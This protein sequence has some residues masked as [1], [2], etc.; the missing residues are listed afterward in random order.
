MTEHEH[1]MY[2]VLGKISETDAPIVFKGALISKLILAEH[3]FTQLE[4]STTDIDA[5]WVD[6]PP[7]MSYL[8]NTIQQSLGNMRDQL[9]AV[10][11]RDYEEK[12]SAGISIRTKN[13]DKEIMSMD[14]SIKPV[15]GIKVYYYGEI[16]IKGVFV[17][18]ILAD[19]ITILSKKLVFRRAKDLLDVYALTH[20]ISVIT[21]EI[22]EIMQSKRLELGE[23]TE[24]LTRQNDVEHAYKKL[25]G[26]ENKP[27]FDDIYQYLTEFIYPFTQKDKM[28][29]IWNKDNR[30]WDDINRTIEKPSI[31]DQLRSVRL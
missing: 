21:T 15:I 14:I 4:R 12:K 29:R 13:M 6:T 17:N 10:A 9:Y 5:N 7:S 30:N 8:V 28:P 11:I 16:G 3:G 31:R 25:K 23:F 1:L 27:L 19:K 2:Q 22:F 26:V 20:C 18:E 24:F